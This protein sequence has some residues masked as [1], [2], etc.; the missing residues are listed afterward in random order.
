[1]EVIPTRAAKKSLTR[2]K[3]KAI[4]AKQRTADECSLEIEFPT[5]MVLLRIIFCSTIGFLEQSSRR[6]DFGSVSGEFCERSR[7]MRRIVDP[8]SEVFA[9]AAD[10]CEPKLVNKEIEYHKNWYPVCSAF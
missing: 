7:R 1:M 9:R 10:C 6:S 5:S 3:V 4:R 8:L 2:R